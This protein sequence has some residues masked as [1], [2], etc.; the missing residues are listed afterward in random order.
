M[1]ISLANASS[2]DERIAEI[3]P[4]FLK[5]FFFVTGPMP[6]TLS[7]RELKLAFPRRLM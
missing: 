6:E 2:E 3:V 7:N 5:S 4:N 1:P